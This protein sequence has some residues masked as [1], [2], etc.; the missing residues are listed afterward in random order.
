[1]KIW[2][3]YLYINVLQIHFYILNDPDLRSWEV[4]CSDASSKTCTMVWLGSHEKGV[5]FFLGAVICIK[6]VAFEFMC[7]WCCYVDPWISWL[8]FYFMVDINNYMI[9]NITGCQC[10]CSVLLESIMRFQNWR[11]HWICIN[12]NC[13]QDMGNAY[14]FR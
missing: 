1:M 2:C 9:N 3:V 7:V 6:W 11:R 4:W 5:T 10:K 12:W 8:V 14:K 13:Q